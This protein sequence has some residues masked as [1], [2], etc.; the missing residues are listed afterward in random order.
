MTQLVM[1]CDDC[2][3][4]FEAERTTAC[5]SCGEIAKVVGPVWSPESIDTSYLFGRAVETV[6][7][8]P[9]VLS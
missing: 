3:V 9:G 7:T 2:D 5:V 1:L 8:K 4:T 6:R